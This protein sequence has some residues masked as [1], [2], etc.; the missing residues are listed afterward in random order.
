MREREI[1]VGE[2]KGNEQDSQR[3]CGID[4][5]TYTYLDIPGESVEPLQQL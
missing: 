3:S 5:I 2:G 4:F 1:L